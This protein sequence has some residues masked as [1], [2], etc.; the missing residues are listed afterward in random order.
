MSFILGANYQYYLGF[1]ALCTR[2]SA[3]LPRTFCSISYIFDNGF[4]L[5]ELCLVPRNTA[6]KSFVSL[7]WCIP[8]IW[9]TAAEASMPSAGGVGYG[10][11]GWFLPARGAGG[12]CDSVWSSRSLP[13]SSVVPRSP[14]VCGLGSLCLIQALWD[15]LLL[16]LALFSEITKSRCDSGLRS[17]MWHTIQ[18]RRAAR[19]HKC[20]Q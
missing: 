12:L 8:K 15:F 20:S 18:H 9:G 13:V 3:L 4:I 19:L 16:L 10:P 11:P 1:S 5:V 7:P 17:I 14:E 2:I 6:L